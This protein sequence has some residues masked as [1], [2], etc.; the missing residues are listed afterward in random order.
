MIIRWKLNYV[1]IHIV[2][3]KRLITQ[4]IVILKINFVDFKHVFITF[5]KFIIT[6]ILDK[7][8]NHGK[9]TG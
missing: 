9:A 3:L 6:I 7:Y 1:I 8:D 4:I 2:L 5:W